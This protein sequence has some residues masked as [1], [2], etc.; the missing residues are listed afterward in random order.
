MK[1]MILI[2]CW[3]F[4][5]VC[6]PVGV[7][8]R[9]GDNAGAGIKAAPAAS[10]ETANKNI[11]GVTEEI[12]SDGVKTVTINLSEIDENKLPEKYVPEVI[13]EAPIIGAE[14]GE[15]TLELNGKMIAKQDMNG[16]MNLGDKSFTPDGTI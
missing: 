9:G 2:I 11:P 4:L 7:M 10:A 3:L 5:I 6:W 14:S 16:I 13:L 12:G 1:K 15:G 8:L